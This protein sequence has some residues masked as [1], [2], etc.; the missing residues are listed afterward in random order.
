MTQFAKTYLSKRKNTKIQ[1]PNEDL[2]EVQPK[3]QETKAIQP[4]KQVTR[5][6]Y[7]KS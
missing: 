6:T 7:L 2:K 3:Y 1:N 5:K 4:L